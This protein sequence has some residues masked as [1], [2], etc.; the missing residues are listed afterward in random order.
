MG[1]IEEAQEQT[2]PFLRFHHAD[3]ERGSKNAR[4]VLERPQEEKPDHFDLWLLRKLQIPANS[5]NLACHVYPIIGHYSDHPSSCGE[6]FKGGVRHAHWESTWVAEGTRAY[7]GGNRW[8]CSFA[9]P[10][11]SHW[12]MEIKPEV[13]TDPR[14]NWLT[15][16]PP[17]PEA[18]DLEPVAVPT[19]HRVP[20]GEQA[21]RPPGLAAS[22]SG[23]QRR[24]YRKAMSQ[25]AERVFT[26][27]PE[28]VVFATHAC[29][30]FPHP[31][32]SLHDLFHQRMRSHGLI[33]VCYRSRC[34]IS[35]APLRC[36][37]LNRLTR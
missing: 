23:R 18:F 1:G 32:F 6:E 24:Q 4:M 11:N 25:L 31:W 36:K 8:L 30:Y 7:K 9:A 34:L 33:V 28:G 29:P 35:H 20:H 22:Q 17:P 5:D 2:R 14:G 27:R 37:V 10:S 26:D 21:V 3:P 13:Y 12:L 16:R 15:L 19:R